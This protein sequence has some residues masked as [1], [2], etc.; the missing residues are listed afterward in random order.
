MFAAHVSV[1]EFHENH[2]KNL[3]EYR[4]ENVN[5]HLTTY[6]ASRYIYIYIFFPKPKRIWLYCRGSVVTR[7]FVF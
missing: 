5:G 2:G 3:S 7:V 6:N 1:D 4:A